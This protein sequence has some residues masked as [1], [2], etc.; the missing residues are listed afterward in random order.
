MRAWTCGESM[1]E[2]TRDSNPC[3]QDWWTRG[4][5]H[6][7]GESIEST[8]GATHGSME[9]VH[10]GESTGVGRAA[11]TFEAITDAAHNVLARPR[12]RG[13]RQ[14]HMHNRF[15]HQ[16]TNEAAIMRNAQGGP[17]VSVASRPRSSLEAR[18]M[19]RECSDRCRRRFERRYVSHVAFSLRS[20]TFA[21]RSSGHL[22]QK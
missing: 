11:S 14:T 5:E 22:I 17:T 12:H 10:G 18:D 16:F 7:A 19:G 21:P 13:L 4:A 15:D 20:L 2:L 8:W 3:G 9:S 6:G 1:I